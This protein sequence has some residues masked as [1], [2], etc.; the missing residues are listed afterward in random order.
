MTR[1]FVIIQ[2]LCLGLLIWPFGPLRHLSG[3]LFIL[4]GLIIG[5]AA[6]LAQP[7]GNFNIR[8]DLKGGAVLVTGGIYRY[9]RHPMYSSVLVCALGLV[10]LY[11]SPLK[12]VVYIILFVNMILKLLYEERLWRRA[13]E[14][15]EAYCRRTKRLIPFVI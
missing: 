8:P 2:F 15:Y 9:I 11:S 13:D 3:G 14:N 7:R 12:I 5:Y 6:I 10:V 1:I 4:A